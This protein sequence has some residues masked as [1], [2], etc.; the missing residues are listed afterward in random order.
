M[1]TFSLGLMGVTHL[2]CPPGSPKVFCDIQFPHQRNEGVACT[3]SLLASFLS[4]G[5]AQLPRSLMLKSLRLG[6]AQ[7]FCVQPKWLS[8]TPK[9]LSLFE[10][11]ILCTNHD[12]GSRVKWFYRGS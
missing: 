6:M 11:V 7:I 4:S 12:L 2:A 5:F 8:L 10:F 9:T 3:F 1:V